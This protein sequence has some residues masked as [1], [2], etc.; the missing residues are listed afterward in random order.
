MYKFIHDTVSLCNECY[1]HIPAVVYEHEEKIKMR[2][3]CHEHGTQESIVEVDPDFYYS[4]NHTKDVPAFNY[5]FFEASDRCQLNCPHCYHLPDNKIQDKPIPTLIEQVKQF[6]KDSKIMIA[7]AEPTLRSD[8]AM[9]CSDINNLG[10]K[11]FSVLT[12]GLRFASEEFTK[13]CKNA[14]LNHVSF[15]LNHPNYQGNSVHNKQLRAI[16]ILKE[17]EIYIGY[18][19]YTIESLEELPFILEEIERLHVPTFSASTDLPSNGISHYRIRCGSFIGRSSDIERSYLSNTFKRIKELLGDVE[20]GF[21]DDDNPYHIMVKKGDIKIR[22]IQWP[23]KTNIDME[24]LASAPWCNFYNGP[25]T[26]FVHQTIMRDAFINNGL[27]MLDTVPK[28][29]QYKS[30][31]EHTYWKKDWKGPIECSTLK[32]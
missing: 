7:G 10:Y 16:D 12:N 5:V 13:Q 25:I 6:P 1:R 23:D 27:P 8:F 28:K 20:V 9:L 24:E 19:G 26:N 17:Q 21:L 2:K 22:I 32:I 18:V 14:G 3:V 29:Y 30:P 31:G 15:G 11:G 4:L